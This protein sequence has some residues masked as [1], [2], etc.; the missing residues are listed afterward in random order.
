MGIKT[1]TISSSKATADEKLNIEKQIIECEKNNKIVE[2]LTC[3]RCGNEI[4]FTEIG[5]SYTIK[6]K[7][8]DCIRYSVRGI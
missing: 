3:P 2:N 8:S 5:N 4:I 6:C 7:T 1:A